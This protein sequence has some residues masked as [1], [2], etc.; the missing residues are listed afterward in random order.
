MNVGYKPNF[1]GGTKTSA[2][3]TSDALTA[4]AGGLSLQFD[5]KTGLLSSASRAGKTFS[6]VNGPRLL[7]GDPAGGGGGRRGAPATSP[8]ALADSTLTSFTQKADGNDLLLSAA[9]DGPM[10][11]ITYR[12]HPNGWLTIDY[13]YNLTGPHALFGIG[14]D[15]PEAYVQGMR[16]LGNGPAPVFQNRLAGGTLDVWEKKYNN[17]MVG[18][19]DDL[20]PGQHFDYPVFKGYYAGV[21]WLQLSTTEGPIT[22]LLNQDDLYVQVFTPKLPPPNIQMNTTITYAKAGISFLHAISAMGSKFSG[23]ASTGPQGQPAVAK[24]D[25]KGSISLFFGELPKS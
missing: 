20:A 14:F 22:A 4:T 24:G 8:A 21:R 3:E 16:Y 25:Y 10:K 2:A 19:P 17:T 1:A 15:Y 18:D 23:P 7:T 6:F 9:F 12:V 5:K 13:A 11:S